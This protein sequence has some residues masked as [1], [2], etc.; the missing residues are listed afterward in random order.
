MDRLPWRTNVSP[1]QGAYFFNAREAHAVGGPPVC[2][3]V[4]DA[5]EDFDWTHPAQGTAFS[6]SCMRQVADLPDIFG[7]YGAVPTYLLTYPVLSDPNVVCILQRQLEQGQCDVGVQLHP[8]VN[9]PFDPDEEQQVS[10]LGSL[11]P[12]LEERKLL[13]LQDKFRQCFGRPPTSFRT[14]RYGLGKRTA[15]LLE[16]HGF[17]VDTSLAPRT[18]FRNEN[19]PDFTAYDC[20]PFWFGMARDLLELPLCRSLI[21]WGGAY[22]RTLYGAASTPGLAR[23]HMPAILSRLRCAERITL[24]PEGNDTPAMLRFLRSRL[25]AGQTLFSLSFHSSSLAVG[26]NPYVRSRADLH[27]FYDRLSGV[28][29]AM[30]SRLGF[31]FATLAQMPSLLVRQA[32]NARA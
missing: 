4:I 1:I 12:E 2:T 9:P 3:V 20:D 31:Q 29:D 17:L 10:F 28:L 21:G 30:E 5:E 14:G 16:K 6:T 8:W 27:A 24:S 19:G 32:A 26:H 25:S 23:W 15:G 11:P 7:A 13:A 18:D 22:A